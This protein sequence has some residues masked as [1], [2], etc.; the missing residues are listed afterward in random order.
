MYTFQAD[1]FVPISSLNPPDAG[2]STNVKALA[3][4]Q[5]GQSY[6]ASGDQLINYSTCDDQNPK[7]LAG[8]PINLDATAIGGV[9]HVV[10]L[11]LS[12][13]LWYDYR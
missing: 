12:D 2:L 11:S 10:G 1:T 13:G 3:W 6:F 4:M 7:T 9:P 5:D 8:T